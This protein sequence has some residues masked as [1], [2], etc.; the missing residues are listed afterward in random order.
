LAQQVAYRRSGAAQAARGRTGTA[1]L[2]TIRHDV[3]NGPDPDGF[4]YMIKEERRG[5]HGRQRLSVR[6]AKDRS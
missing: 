1:A 3:G 6:R 2:T 4:D 5:G